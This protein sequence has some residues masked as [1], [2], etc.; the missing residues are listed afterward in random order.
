MISTHGHLSKL[1]VIGKKSF[2]SLSGLYLS[3]GKHRMFL[4]QIGIAY[5]LRVCHEFDPGSD[6]QA[7]GQYVKKMHNSCLGHIL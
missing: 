3:Y 7:Q 1:S 6:V 5:D 2:I 4:L